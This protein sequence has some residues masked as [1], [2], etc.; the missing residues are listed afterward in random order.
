MGRSP[1]SK[2]HQRPLAEFLPTP[3]LIIYFNYF[4][5]LFIPPGPGTYES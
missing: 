1:A 5:Y 3:H 4:I 2:R